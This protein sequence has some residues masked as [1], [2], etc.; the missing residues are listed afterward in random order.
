MKRG[1]KTPPP[2]ASSILSVDQKAVV[3]AIAGAPGPFFLTGSAGSG[4]TF[5]INFLRNMVPRCV[6]TA[7]TGAA[8][9]LVHGRTLHSFASIHPQ[10]GAVRSEK[11]NR[12]VRECDLLVIDEISMASVDV[13]EQLYDRFDHAGHHPKL[14]MVGDFMQLPPVEGEKLFGSWIWAGCKV[15]K[16]TTQHRQAN[17][18][19]ISVLNDVRRGRLTEQVAAFVR[20]RT[21]KQLPDD[22]THLM[23]TRDPVARR[24]MQKLEELE[25][26][27]WTSRIIIDNSPLRAAPTEL[28]MKRIRFPHLLVLKP[29]ARIVLLTN[30]QAGRWV[31][32][33]TGVVDHVEP[34]TVHV[35]LDAGGRVQV[36]KAEEEVLDAEG[37]PICI[38]RQYPLMLAWA[39]TIHRSQGA[40]LDR[41]GIDLSGHFETGQTYVALS[42]CRHPDGLFL[43]GSLHDIKVDHAAMIYA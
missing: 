7:M 36:T 24:N 16:L 19:F 30:D 34:G 31:N 10:H 32:G 20:S 25:G 26:P 40:T 18:D 23:A 39:L 17:I 13:I 43:T 4:K 8:A 6:V 9:Q 38:V 11:A 2:K 14:L 28:E 1:K 35:A 21:V 37:K 42:R 5:V 12:R 29:K 22:C 41:V 33:S 27:K 3:D 15:L